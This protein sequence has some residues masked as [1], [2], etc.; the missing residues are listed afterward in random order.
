MKRAHVTIALIL[1]IP[2]ACLA[3]DSFTTKVDEYVRS[4]MQAQQIPGVALAV[5]KDGKV[6]LARGYGLANVEHQVPVK[7]E[8]I[9]QSGSTGKQFTAT[10]VMMLVEEGK[11]SLE[12]K[13]TKHFTDAPE[14]WRDITVRHLLTHT[15]GMTDYPPDF[16]MRRDYT[17][18]ELFQ[19]IKTLAKKRFTKLP[20]WM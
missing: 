18:D 10:A 8:T 3:Q 11:L 7:P 6:V 16:D 2:I 4:E 19:R 12:D 1:L 14:T 20:Y 5:V 15:S 13:I 9:C 17:E